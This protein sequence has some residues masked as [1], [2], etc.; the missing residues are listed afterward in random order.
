MPTE[1]AAQVRGAHTDLTRHFV[2][3]R[4]LMRVLM[5]PN[6]SLQ[7]SC[8]H[9]CSRTADTDGASKPQFHLTIRT[10]LPCPE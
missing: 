10:S 5:Q 3:P 2:G 1:N 4:G 8:V 9:T 7:Q 6:E